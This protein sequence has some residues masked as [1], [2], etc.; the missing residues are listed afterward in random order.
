MRTFDFDT[1]SITALANTGLV[2]KIY[3]VPV[4]TTGG[5]NA[6]PLAGVTITVDGAEQTLR[7]TTAADGSF[8]L[9]PA[10][11]GR[12]FVLID[13]RTATNAPAGGY[14]TFVG[15][16]WEGV[17]GKLDTP[18]TPATATNAAGDIYLPFIPTGTLQAT[19]AAQDTTI[20]FPDAVVA[21]NPGLAGVQ[22]RVP[23]N[24]LFANDGARGGMV[25]IAPVAPDKLPEPLPPG[26]NPA[27]VITIQTD[28]ATN[29]DRP[30]PVRFPNLAAP[31]TTNKLPPGAKTALFSFNHDT[32]RW[33][34]AGPMTVTADGNFVETDA[35]V[36]VRQP[37][38]H[39][40]EP[41]PPPDYPPPDTEGD[42]GPITDDGDD[43]PTPNDG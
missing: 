12:F 31:G 42:D 26:L 20:T 8:T 21:A 2:G 9:T 18:V 25:G 16:A 4:G 38:W 23:A 5:A 15:K 43:N 11:A 19:S 41:P 40:P 34:I 28:G 30:V 3:G 17:P 32:G 35:G 13:G 7:T 36:G 37:G 6:T 27:L 24:A 14:Y 29:F 22:I 10:P 33:E 39:A 1:L